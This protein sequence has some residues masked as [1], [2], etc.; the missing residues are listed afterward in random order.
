MLKNKIIFISITLLIF[1]LSAS[2]TTLF[3]VQSSYRKEIKQYQ[4]QSKI[5]DQIVDLD[6]NKESSAGAQLPKQPYTEKVVNYRTNEQHEEKLLRIK[7]KYIPLNLLSYSTKKSIDSNLLIRS[8]DLVSEYRKFSHKYMDAKL[9]FKAE[10]D[11]NYFMLQEDQELELDVFSNENELKSVGKLKLLSG[12][13]Y[14]FPKEWIVTT[15]HEVFLEHHSYSINF[16]PNDLRRN[17]KGEFINEKNSSWNQVNK[18]FIETFLKKPEIFKEI[19]RLSYWKKYSIFS[20]NGTIINKAYIDLKEEDYTKPIFSEDNLKTTIAHIEGETNDGNESTMQLFKRINNDKILEMTIGQMRK[21]MNEIT[22]NNIIAQINNAYKNSNQYIVVD[23]EKN[24][25]IDNPYMSLRETLTAKTYSGNNVNVFNVVNLG[26]DKKILSGVKHNI[27]IPINE[28]LQPENKSLFPFNLQNEENIVFEREYIPKIVSVLFRGFSTHVNY[29]DINTIYDFFIDYHKNTKLPYKVH[30]AK[31]ILL[32]DL[33]L[34]PKY[35]RF[36]NDN[37]FAITSKDSGVHFI[38]LA[39]KNGIWYNLEQ[40]E[41]TYNE[42]I[43]YLNENPSFSL[44][45]V[46]GKSG[47]TIKHPWKTNELIVPFI[48]RGFS[49]NLLREINKA[50]ST[51]LIFQ[52]VR[53]WYTDSTIYTK[54]WLAGYDQMNLLMKGTQKAFEENKLFELLTKG[55]YDVENVLKAVV[56]IMYYLSDTEFLNKNSSLQNQYNGLTFLT[57]F[58]I[59]LIT[60]M[61]ERYL[62]KNFAEKKWYF[63]KQIKNIGML[64]GFNFDQTEIGKL[65][66]PLWIDQILENKEMLFAF[67]QN[68]FTT[69]NW[70]KFSELNRKIYITNNWKSLDNLKENEFYYSVSVSQIIINLL[71]SINVQKFLTHLKVFI[72]SW[73]VDKAFSIENSEMFKYLFTK[74]SDNELKNQI[75][76]FL[77]KIKQNN[78]FNNIKLLLQKL[79]DNFDWNFMVQTIESSLHF[80]QKNVVF[81]GKNIVVR[82]HF[83]TWNDVWFILLKTFFKDKETIEKNIKLIVQ[84]LNLS[85][86]ILV[87]SSEFGNLP[88]ENT[89]KFTIFDIQLLVNIIDKIYNIF[90]DPENDLWNRLFTINEI[91]STLIEKIQN[92]NLNIKDIKLTDFISIFGILNK[93]EL[94]DSS[95]VIEFL[96]HIQEIYKQFSFNY[97]GNSNGALINKNVNIEDIKNFSYGDHAWF[98]SSRSTKNSSVPEVLGQKYILQN[99]TYP[100]LKDVRYAPEKILYFYSFWIQFAYNLYLNDNKITFTRIQKILEEFYNLAVLPES[101]VYKVLNNI[102]YSYQVIGK[103]IGTIPIGFTPIFTE[104]INLFETDILKKFKNKDID[105]FF[106]RNPEAKKW[107]LENESKA[108]EVLTYL[109][110]SVLKNEEK[111]LTENHYA[112]AILNFIKTFLIKN[113]QMIGI[114]G[115]PEKLKRLAKIS[116]INSNLN[117]QLNLLGIP[118]FLLNPFLAS[119][120]PLLIM[121]LILS[122]NENTKFKGNIAF[123]ISAISQKIGNT[124]LEQQIKT[125]GSNWNENLNLQTEV[126]EEIKENNLILDETRYFHLINMLSRYWVFE[127]DFGTDFILGIIKQV[128][129]RVSQNNFFIFSNPLSHLIKVNETWANANNKQIYKGVLPQ[130]S[131]QMQN[132]INNLDDKYVV[133]IS[134]VRFLIVGYDISGDYLYPVIDEQHLQVNSK[135]QAIAYVN[136]L[137]FSR[138]RDTGVAKSYLLIKSDEG[139]SPQNWKQNII[140]ILKKNGISNAEKKVFLNTEIDPINPERA[141]R[142]LTI[143]KLTETINTI[144]I[145]LVFI[146]TILMIIS[147]SFVVKRF[148]KTRSKSIGILLSLGYKKIEIAASFL[149]FATLVTFLGCVSGISLGSVLKYPLFKILSTFW[150]LPFKSSPNI[151][152]PMILFVLGIF[153]INVL[154]IFISVFRILKNKPIE[155][156]NST[157]EVNYSSF[158]LV[159]LKLFRK[160]SFKTKFSFALFLKSFLKLL[161]L[162]V[163]GLLSAFITLFGITSL[164]IFSN[165]LNK[166][167][168]NRHYNYKIEL[169]TPTIEGGPYTT[170]S[171]NN[172]A[173]NLYVPDLNVT[174]PDGRKQ[175][176]GTVDIMTQDFFSPT[177]SYVLEKS[178]EQLTPVVTSKTAL[179]VLFDTALA[180]NPW[181]IVFNEIPESQK[182]KI[183]NKVVEV[184]TKLQNTQ[185]EKDKNGNYIIPKE[186]TNYF[187]YIP[188]KNEGDGS[189]N[190]KIGYFVYREWDNFYHTYKESRINQYSAPLLKK[191]LLEAYT[192]IDT[193]DFFISFGGLLFNSNKPYTGEITNETYSYADVSA[194][195][196]LL[197]IEGY[198]AHSKFVTIRNENT[199]NLLVEVEKRWNIESKLPVDQRIYP[200]IV[201]HV[202]QKITGLEIG[203]IFEGEVENRVDRFLE[204]FSKNTNKKKIKFEVI[205]INDTYINEEIITIQPVINSITGLD[206]LNFQKNSD[207]GYK[208]EPFNGILSTDEYPIQVTESSS[209]YSLNGFWAPEIT[210]DYNH[211]PYEDVKNFFENVFGVTSRLQKRGV[212]WEEIKSSLIKNAKIS[213]WKNSTDFDN[214]AENKEFVFWALKYFFQIYGKNLYVPAFS[215]IYSLKTE[216]QFVEL[217]A[218]TTEKIFLIL[219]LGFFAILAIIFLIISNIVILEN[220]I[221]IGIT[222]LLGFVAKEKFQ[223]FFAFY[224]PIVVIASIAAI[225]LVNILIPIFNNFLVFSL[226]IVTPLSI[227]VWHIILMFV[228]EILLFFSV[229]SYSWIY[230]KRIKVVEVS[231]GE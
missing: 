202:T 42:L 181:D 120:F 201:N 194:L 149:P 135:Q 209:I 102:S 158:I 143:F 214:I 76:K 190:T 225:P 63:Q 54:G 59:H 68:I 26:N 160:L 193:D 175:N 3:S 165:A 182:E 1:I 14:Y 28:A 173:K 12:E 36:S 116:N 110:Y 216:N 44:D 210:F 10:E 118:N 207:T 75:N 170:F 35:N 95:K 2:F 152:F 157:N 121:S 231:Q 13:K 128:L 180:I 192:K 56:D 130:N 24:S 199:T 191:F 169:V 103:N 211:A 98:A 64:L 43:E 146:I 47:W 151:I 81:N 15:K 38:I 60:Q 174:L 183:I 144:T 82:S 106:E 139:Y 46:V 21:K 220:K 57:N 51:D 109:N 74:I 196:K 137:G 124:N 108:A 72:N 9:T 17:E 97:F 71:K 142:I 78:S 37:K 27:A 113:D 230:L 161:I 30:N 205:G 150:V 154:V 163:S 105:H 92:K 197:K 70:T 167:Y 5:H 223:M 19:S 204:N 87:G 129:K 16:D 136:D 7:E 188:P 176:I 222:S 123:T 50:N 79:I 185:F 90:F 73:N 67:L 48:Y 104:Q 164:G 31:I 85:D 226:S 219:I 111:F 217:A 218:N 138:I 119:A 69:I 41:L 122:P 159:L 184:S 83:V 62:A 84:H 89:N 58:F 179:D 156:I 125:L 172:L 53:E 186:K 127:F 145:I 25:Y 215:K 112:S 212:T 45:A 224:I 52:K 131:L 100:T 107:I 227:K 148:V 94:E 177:N 22:K 96:Q 8:F 198:K 140:E 101:S 18:L 203:S 80:Q 4:T 221:N 200:I 195:G 91:S 65:F 11:K 126:Y 29:L 166:T 189:L 99:F 153:L 23:A 171:R 155:L 134:G 114:A 40:R 168:L 141:L 20:I 32:K 162:L 61:K 229:I 88:S 115:T 213:D 133:N 34:N 6:F 147:T 206:S 86:A 187:W 117:R 228:L 66:N 55:K 33:G 39:K 49:Q 93:K 208:G 77:N 132:L 178:G